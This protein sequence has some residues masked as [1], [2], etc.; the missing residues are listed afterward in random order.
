MEEQRKEK[1]LKEKEEE[2]PRNAEQEAIEKKEK[3]DQLERD[4]STLKACVSAAD[5]AIC[6]GNKKSKSVFNRKKLT[7]IK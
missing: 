7:L 4:D 3:M 2:E 5:Q 6:S 1:K